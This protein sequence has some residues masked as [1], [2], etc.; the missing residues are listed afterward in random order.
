MLLTESLPAG[1]IEY[2]LLQEESNLDL[3]DTDGHQ[4]GLLHWN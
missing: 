3:A 2:L 1:I 4:T